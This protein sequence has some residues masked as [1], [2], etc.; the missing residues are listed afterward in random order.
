M[1]SANSI[2]KFFGQQDLFKEI[3][4]HL[5][6][7]ERIGL[8]GPN[9]AGK[10]TLLKILLGEVEPDSGQVH[11]K[12]GL[13]IGFL[14]QEVIQL[15]GKTVLGQVMEVEGALKT[16][17]TEYREISRRLEKE[18]D[19]N[20]TWELAKRQSQL[21]DE[22]E[23]MGAY[24]FESRA[25]QVLAGLGFQ[26][27]EYALPVEKLSGGWMM[28]VALARLLLAQ[29]DLLLLDEPTNH[30]DL[31][32]LLWLENFLSGTS[33][34]LLL[35]SHDRAF[36]DRVVEKILEIDQGTM[37]S[38]PG[39]Y[40]RY[41]EEKAKRRQIQ[42]AS[43]RHQEERIKQIED[44]IARNRTRKD[45]AKQVQSRIKMLEK[46]ER[47]VPPGAE[48]RVSFRFPASA[49]S[50]KV[51]LDFSGLGKSFGS[52]HLYQDVHFNILSGDKVAILGPNG[53]GKSTLLKLMAGLETPDSGECLLG[54]NVTIGYFAQH[55]LEQL[56]GNLTVWEEARSIAGD[57]TQGDLRNL[58]AA[59]LF[60]NQDIQ[61]KVSVLSGGE[62]S[63]LV[64]LKILLQAPNLIL[65]DEPTNHLDIPS[66]DVLEEALRSFEGTVL[67]ITHDRHLINALANKVIYIREDRVELFPGNYSD[68][69]EIWISRLA[70]PQKAKSAVRAPRKTQEDKKKAAEDRNLLSR[71]KA[72]LKKELS[73][74][75]ERL[76]RALEE[77]DN[78][79]KALAHPRTYQ[80]N[81]DIQELSRTYASVRKEIGS[82]SEHWEAVTRKLEEM[83]QIRPG[84]TAPR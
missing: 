26:E 43:F 7:G 40:S 41:L 76:A 21:L 16:I 38:Y 82:L 73:E 23:R 77:K 70:A 74:V 83:D 32:S 14:P 12:K 67:I 9:G 47:I 60:R 37:T 69:E 27:H 75:E 44:F 2:S 25:K 55:Q 36:L 79:E 45:R 42:E 29:P 49:R 4:F 68:F 51:V 33:S 46:M 11:V 84:I 56:T 10:T 3:S 8:V 22:L 28:R 20:L 62:K 34:A 72:P 35:I 63:R 54:H 52:H 57:R 19:P 39:N 53:E 31:D 66:R 61:K 59:F 64:I 81:L 50:G 5:N 80:G 18:K 58:L 30:L 1:I 78:L 17:Q 15:K 65:L 48:E 13:R 6:P 71:I 24:H